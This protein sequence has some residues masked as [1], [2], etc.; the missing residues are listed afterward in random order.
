MTCR[1]VAR[2]LFLPLNTLLFNMAGLPC[3][4]TVFRNGGGPGTLVT[5]ITVAA[6][7]R[8]FDLREESKREISE[9]KQTE[10]ASIMGN[11]QFEDRVKQRSAELQNANTRL[12]KDLAER[13]WRTR[14]YREAP[15]GLCCLDTQLRYLDINESLAALNG[16]SVEEHLGRSVSE[17]FPELAAGIESQFRH[18]IETGEPIVEGSVFAETPAE[19]GVKRYFQ[20]NYDAIKSDD[21]AIVGVS[22][23]VIEVTERQRAEEE[24]KSSEDRYYDLYNNAPDMFASIDAATGKIIECN[25]TL[26]AATG[27]SKQELLALPHISHLYHPNSEEARQEFFDAF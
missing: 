9:R 18:V 27:Y 22:C 14:I 3:W 2:N 16:L 25:D 24:R 26:A 15:V 7:G 1:L 17:L 11:E 19:P 8:P 13:N 21:G 23:A 6:D 20:H 5:L 12:E 4:D 10:E